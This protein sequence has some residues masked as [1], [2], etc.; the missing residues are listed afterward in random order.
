MADLPAVLPLNQLPGDATNAEALHWV[1]RMRRLLDRWEALPE[2]AGRS[3]TDE[4]RGE[5]SHQLADLEDSI[6]GNMR[7]PPG[8]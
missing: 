6:R 3:M 2:Y 7:V 5:I 4:L 8:A 1:N